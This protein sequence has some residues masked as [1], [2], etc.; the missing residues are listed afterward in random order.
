MYLCAVSLFRDDDLQ[1]MFAF[2]PPAVE[3]L[4]HRKRRGEQADPFKAPRV[5]RC[6]SRIGNVEQR[7]AGRILNTRGKFVHCV[8]A[9]DDHVRPAAFERASAIGQNLAKLVP[10]ARMLEPLDLAEIKRMQENL[11]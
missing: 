4:L 7:Q 3:V 8:G 5:D 2:E 10:L 9:Q 11:R 1:S 6:G